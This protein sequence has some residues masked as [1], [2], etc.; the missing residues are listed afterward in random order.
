MKP[1]FLLLC[2]LFV[3]FAEPQ[4]EN[5]Y[6]AFLFTFLYSLILVSLAI[7]LLETSPKSSLTPTNKK[8]TRS[9]TP[10]RQCSYA[11]TNWVTQ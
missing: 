3:A 11:A 2:C 8:R 5:D 10:Q 9:T 4:V 1:T 6:V 7:F